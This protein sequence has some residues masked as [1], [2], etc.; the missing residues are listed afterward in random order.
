MIAGYATPEG[1]AAYRRRVAPAASEHFRSL[2]GCALSSVGFG[3][4]L[5][6]EDPATDRLYRDAAIRALELGANLIDSAINYRYQR[7][8]RAIGEALAQLIGS[9]RLRREEVAVAT[10][11]GFIP[12]DGAPP[13][14]RDQYVGYILET[15]VGPGVVRTEDIAVGC[16]CMTPAYLRHQLD[17]SR[18]NLGLECL[19]VYYVHS[20]EMQLQEIG[21][22]E[23]RSRVRAAFETLEQSVREGKTRVYGTATWSG[24]RQKPEEKDYLCLADLVE[25]AREVGGE[26]HHFR[27]IQLP[28]NLAMPE[29]VLLANQPVEGRMVPLLQ[30]ARH[31]GVS[32]MASASIFQGRVARN[33]P[34]FVGEA[35]PGFS[36]DAQRALQFTRSTPG[37]SVALVGMKNPRH[38]QENLAVA[39]FPPAPVEDY[40]RLFRPAEG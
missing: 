1:T 28:V 17:T 23:F 25:V 36:T 7:S 39:G 18:R 13:T 9:G 15:F 5:G 14:S 40:A 33:L 24:Y 11:G 12:F 21:R 31:F 34:G 37:L 3:T 35:F 8:E 27:A 20:P 19:D 38:I 22:E 26:G 30:A 16:H 6:A 29:A 10:K 4:Y 32:V 2:A